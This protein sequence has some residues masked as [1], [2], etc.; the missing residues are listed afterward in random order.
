MGFDFNYDKYFQRVEH[1]EN[2]VNSLIDLMK[3]NDLEHTMEIEEVL[4]MNK[5]KS[6]GF[7]RV[8]FITEEIKLPERSTKY[9]AGYDFFAYQDIIIPPSFVA[10]E[11]IALNLES[12]HRWEVKP[13]LVKTGIKAFMQEDEVLYL[14]NRSSNPKK[15]L[16]LANSVGVVDSDYYNNPSNEGEIGFLFYNIFPYRIIIKKGD[17]IGQGVFSKY[18]LI[19]DD[20]SVNIREGGFG[21]TGG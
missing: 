7:E 10:K 11:E 19:D 9:S 5:S 20:L 4:K 21:S 2:S 12:E 14:Y 18:L 6:R 17:K 16:I 8:S 15:G 13:F 3:K 1:I